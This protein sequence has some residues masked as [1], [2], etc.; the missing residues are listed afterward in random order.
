M[1]KIFEFFEFFW[2]FFFFLGLYGWCCALFWKHQNPAQTQ[3]SSTLHSSSH[4]PLNSISQP[5]SFLQTIVNP[6]LLSFL[7]FISIRIHGGPEYP[8][9]QKVTRS[10]HSSHF[11]HFSHHPI[12]CHDHF[13]TSCTWVVSQGQKGLVRWLLCPFF[14]FEKEEEKKRKR[15]REVYAWEWGRIVKCLVVKRPRRIHGGNGTR[16]EISANDKCEIK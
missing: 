15:K 3:T 14:P 11:L 1:L 5:I 4:F 8:S 13:S 2:I 10:F 9:P 7:H 16:R 12:F 6:S